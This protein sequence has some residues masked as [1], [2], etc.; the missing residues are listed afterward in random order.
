LI[1]VTDGEDHEGNA[2]EMA[3]TAR[4]QGLRIHCIGVGSAEGATIPEVM[5]GRKIGEKRDDA[6]QVVVSRLNPAMLTSIAEAGGGSYYSLRDIRQ[7]IESL[8]TDLDSLTEQEFDERYITDYEDQFSWMLGIAL[9]LL[10]LEAF[11]SLRV[12]KES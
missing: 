7:T 8:E 12:S 9:L 3:A 2:L 11:F 10:T 4:Q 6:G 5:A 1:I